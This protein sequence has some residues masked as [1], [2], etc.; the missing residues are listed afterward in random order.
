MAR[1][2]EG[3]IAVFPDDTSFIADAELFIDG[4]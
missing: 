2:L 1:K 4:G 3:K